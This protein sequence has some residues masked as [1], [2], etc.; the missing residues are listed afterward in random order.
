MQMIVKETGNTECVYD[1]KYDGSG[2][3]HFLIYKDG[4]W[5]LK[6]AKYF[7]PPNNEDFERILRESDFLSLSPCEVGEP[8]I[9]YIG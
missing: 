4:Q 2:F 3:P 5:I 7:R 8:K 1:I 9:D 6:S